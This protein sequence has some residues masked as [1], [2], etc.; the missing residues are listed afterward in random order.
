VN[1][2][3]HH[4]FGIGAVDMPATPDRIHAAIRAAVLAQP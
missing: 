1:D 2:A 4:A 3:L